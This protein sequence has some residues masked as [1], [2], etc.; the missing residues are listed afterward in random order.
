MLE[1]RTWVSFGITN[2]SYLYAESPHSLF[3]VSFFRGNGEIG[4]SYIMSLGTFFYRV[5]E[6][7]P[8]FDTQWLFP[9]WVTTVWAVAISF[10]TE[11]LISA[12]TTLPEAIFAMKAI[13]TYCN[14]SNDMKTD[15]MVPKTKEDLSNWDWKNKMCLYTLSSTA[16]EF[17]CHKLTSSGPCS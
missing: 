8:T 9:S 1:Q 11:C 15:T 4:M 14:W 6:I 16:Q 13:W 5:I 10:L 17:V 12:V 2:G 7:T 3:V